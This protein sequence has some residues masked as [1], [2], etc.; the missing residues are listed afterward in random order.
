MPENKNTRN[1]QSQS[2]LNSGTHLEALHSPVKGKT[3]AAPDKHLTHEQRTALVVKLI[4]FLKS[5]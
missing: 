3:N 5:M 4:D 2:A 1:F